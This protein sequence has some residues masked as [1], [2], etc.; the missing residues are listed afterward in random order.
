MQGLLYFVGSEKSILEI[1]KNQLF[2]GDCLEIL[3]KYL[4]PQNPD[5]FIDLVYI[6]PPFN[7]K[8]DYNVLFE[9][10]DLNDS[11]AQKQAFAD[12]WSNISYM[13]ELDR[14]QDLNIDLYD[15]L[16]TLEKVKTPRSAVAYLTTMAL[17]IIY[18][19]KVLKSTGSFYL[20][21]DP[22]MSHY[23]KIVCDMVFGHGNFRNEITWERTKSLK[24]SQFK[25]RKFGV[26]TDIILFYTR[27][28]EYTFNSEQIKRQYTPEDIAERYPYKDAKGFYAKSPLFRSLSM[29]ER[30]NLCYEY[31]GVSSPNRAGWKVSKP[32]L[33]EIDERG[34]LGW[35]SSGI[36]FRKFRPEQ[37]KGFLISNLWT[38]IESTGGNERLGYPTQKPEA[39]MERI[40]KASSNE[41]DL[42]ADFFCGCGT[43]IA[44][45]QRLGR[46][47]LGVDISHLAVKLIMDRV[48]KPWEDNPSRQKEIRNSIEV[49]G[50]PRD[51][52]G[53]K[54]L[55]RNTARGRFTFQDWI[56]E[57]MLGGV[58]NQKKSG[59]G[60]YDGY[61]TFR[62]L[63]GHKGVILIEVKSGNVGVK[64]IREFIQ[65]VE[66]Q[67]ADMGVFV[68]FRDQYSSGMA[69]EARQA[70]YYQQDVYKDK[71]QKIRVMTVED[72]LD[73]YELTYPKMLVTTFK[74]ATDKLIKPIEHGNLFEE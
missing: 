33:I 55:A 21:C 63:G 13:D 72:L 12:T 60:G 73:G 69:S 50:I 53:A 56:I 11:T 46:K 37:T 66:K 28:N 6:D 39:L 65:V 27:S 45:A 70:G 41:G 67:R 19:H 35:S 32:K 36:P 38:D 22:T 49:T 9:S 8:R 44:A 4:V 48:L 18:I 64:N 31:K 29:G 74:S 1:M 24:T 17:R 54:E 71:Y 43:T 25:D 47:W 61:I 34:D 58:S 7:S 51:I 59:D 57:F 2:F 15:F 30:P 40:I 20:H 3:E 16:K 42:V 62:G 14:I 26:N 23:L 10:A 52:D 5:G 68:C